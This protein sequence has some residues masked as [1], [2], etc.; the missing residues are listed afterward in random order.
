MKKYNIRA[1]DKVLCFGQLLG[2]C[3]QVSFSL[4]KAGQLVSSGNTLATGRCGNFHNVISEPA[5]D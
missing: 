3:D 2:M 1:D 4:G 5:T